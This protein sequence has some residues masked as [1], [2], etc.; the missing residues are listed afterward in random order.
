MQQK[1]T[2]EID[3]PKLVIPSDWECIGYQIPQKGMGYIPESPSRNFEIAPCD[4]D[5][6][7]PVHKLCFRKV[8]PVD[9]ELESAKKKF[10]V[11]SWFTYSNEP[12]TIY[13]VGHIERRDA[14]NRVR[15]IVKGKTFNLDAELCHPFPLPVWRCCES[16]KPK[17]D[18]EY[19]M[20]SKGSKR[21]FSA[22][23]S[24]ATASWDWT[25][26]IDCPYSNYEW[27]DEGEL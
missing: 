15:I 19:A 17:K 12:D 9:T 2:L 5:A 16:D 27:L 3:T 7:K 4:F 1:I 6:N 14:D 25:S 18:G 21:I 26:V 10:P 24:I 11:G 23:Y 20:R 13:T 22:K 8:E